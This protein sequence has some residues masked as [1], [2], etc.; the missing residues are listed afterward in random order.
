MQRVILVLIPKRSLPLWLQ[1]LAGAGFAIIGFALQLS[2]SGIL[3]GF[4]LLLFVPAVFLSAVVLGKTGG[5][6]T[7]LLGAGLAA[8]FI[9]EP[10]FSFGLQPSATL[11][12]SIFAA[13][14]C[15]MSMLI[16]VLRRTIDKLNESEAAKALLLEE[17]A[18]RTKNDLAIISSAITLQRN[19]SND[20]AV[21]GALESANARLMVVARAQ[22]RL[23]IAE[24]GSRIDLRAYVSDLCRDLGD[25]LRDV[26]PIA[27]RVS[28]PRLLAPSAV[29]ANV[30]LIVNELV[31]N[32]LKY[33]FPGDRGGTIDV[34][35]VCDSQA[36]TIEVRDDGVG[37]AD[38]SKAGLG[39]KLVRL[40]AKQLSGTIEREAADPG[41][42]V[43]VTLNAEGIEPLA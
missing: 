17:L 21:R 37:C 25:L 33:A 18:H 24:S 15:G 41:Y 31:T 13:V 23:R 20:P 28:S 38:V 19:A 9:V 12:I 11:A 7:T 16:E 43:R 3:N 30:G 10:R 32:S 36:L 22:E 14:G 40:L 35:L 4:P 29:A 42:R 8:Y 1:L 34:A 26:R 6:T 39:S 27:V 5:L 2:L